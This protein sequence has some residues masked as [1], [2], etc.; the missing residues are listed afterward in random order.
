MRTGWPAASLWF[1]LAL[2]GHAVALGLVRAG[3]MVGF[4]HY[5]PADELFTSPYVPALA[6]LIL[7]AAAVGLGLRPWWPAVARWMRTRM[8]AGRAIFVVAVFVISSATLSRE[9]WLYVAELGLAATIQLLALATIF[10]AVVAVPPGAGGAVTRWLAAAPG[11][12]AA[13]P[14][15]ARFDRF[16]LVAA[17]WTVL[18]CAALAFFAYERHPH[19]PDEVVYLLHARYFAAG[20]LDLPLPPVPEAFE[21]DLM[22]YEATRWYS[23]VPPG[24]PAFL[25]VGA[26][27]GVPWLVNPLLNGLNVVLAGRLLQRVYDA[28]TARLG[29]LLLASSP[30]FLFMGM[31]FMTHTLT[32]CAA[33]A[34]ALGVAKLRASPRAGAGAVLMAGA[35]IGLLGMIRPLEGL[36]IAVLL[37]FWGLA[38]PRRHGLIARVGPVAAIVLVAVAVSSIQLSYNRTMTG[39]ATTFPLM[40][41]TDSIYGVGTNALGFGANRGLGWPGLDP[42]P[43]HGFIDVL[44]NGNLNVFQVNTEL[45]G[46]ATGSLLPILLLLGLGGLRRP[47]AWMLAVIAA[48]VGVHSF[49][50]FS[51][52]P[53]FGAR[54]WYLI[55]VPCIALAARGID[56]LARTTGP[57][58]DAP[59]GRDRTDP[60]S[61]I[62]GGDAFDSRVHVAALALVAFTLTLFIPWRATDKYHNYRNMRP[63]V[64]QLAA[65]HD[66][67][68]SLILVRGNRHPDYASAAI[69]NP[70]DLASPEPIYA[71]DRSAEVR[72]RVLEVYADRPVWVLDGPTRTGAG[73]RVVE[74]PLP[75]A[76]LL[77]AARGREGPRP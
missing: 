35:G 2:A 32:L 51:G 4:Q 74:G 55:L 58:G 6:F 27:F 13:G 54:Y 44:V 12:D 43:G 41:Y 53:D 24:W 47:D 66:F 5:I 68:H 9:P 34:A 29:V 76:D 28:R 60:S 42:F 16:T 23:P 64:R 75:A 45:L 77:R 10:L 38:A 72:A 61:S 20:L 59:G 36:T 31:N 7:Q 73:F 50:W 33:L 37:G 48:I 26:F 1:L 46:W 56:T 30:W 40:A 18:A 15:S 63:D 21:L 71:W 70:L 49:Y 65:T 8:G 25:A 57:S 62:A 52:G 17:L 69:Y 3:F 39:Q 67:G 11:E 14:G 19:V 22:T